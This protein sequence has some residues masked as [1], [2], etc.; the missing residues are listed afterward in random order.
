MSRHR[1]PRHTDGTAWLVADRLKGGYLCYL[2]TGPADDHLV[3]RA[4]VPSASDAIGWGQR[5]TSRV[6]IRTADG[7]TSWA[8]TAPRPEGITSTWTEPDPSAAVLVG[9][10]PATSGASPC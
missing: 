6:R 1:E 10:A 8:G 3:A 7:H 2:Y 5:R 9:A 4:Y